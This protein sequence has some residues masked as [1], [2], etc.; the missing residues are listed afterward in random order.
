MIICFKLYLIA[1]IGCGSQLKLDSNEPVQEGSG[2]DFFVEAPARPPEVTLITNNSQEPVLGT[3]TIVDWDYL[4][5][6]KIIEEPRKPWESIDPFART[7]ETIIRFDTHVP[8][9]RAS[10][11][12]FVA[13]D[14]DSGLPIDPDSGEPSPFGPAYLEC[15]PYS[16]VCMA[17]DGDTVTWSALPERVRPYEYVSI[18]AEWFIAPIDETIQPG[19]VSASWLFHFVNKNDTEK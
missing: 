19:T 9:G 17:T 13:L 8:P 4:G 5:G 1:V 2:R 10:M 6:E 12:L 15:A 3:L 14:P 7:N 16:E 11:D 18:W